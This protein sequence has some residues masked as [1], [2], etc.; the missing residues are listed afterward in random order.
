MTSLRASPGICCVYNGLISPLDLPAFE[1]F[2]LLCHFFWCLE[3]WMRY[4]WELEIQCGLSLM[5]G[6]TGRLMSG[7]RVLA[8]SCLLKT[9]SVLLSRYHHPNEMDCFILQRVW[10]RPS[11]L[12]ISLQLQSILLEWKA[13]L[14]NKCPQLLHCYH[15]LCSVA[16]L[17]DTSAWV[18][19]VANVSV[20][21]LIPPLC[22][23]KNIVQMVH[24]FSQPD[25][26]YTSKPNGSHIFFMTMKPNRGQKKI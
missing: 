7:V 5:P 15:Q 17:D 18:V 23:S 20:C 25:L 4:K 21:G 22:C 11:A 3:S 13:K 14:E 6:L 16:R 24:E 19:L 26:C 1:T 2:L 8:H 9:S 10:H 12:K